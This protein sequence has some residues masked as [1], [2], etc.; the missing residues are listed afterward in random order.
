VSYTGPWE[1]AGFGKGFNP[2]AVSKETTHYDETENVTEIEKTVERQPGKTVWDLLAILLA[3]VIALA[4]ALLNRAQT[5]RAQA[6]Q[7]QSTQDDVLQDYFNQLGDLL[8]HKDTPLR[9]SNK[10]DE[11]RKLAR[12]RTLTTLGQLDGDRKRS[13]LQFLYESGLIDKTHPIID[14]SGADLK[15]ANLRDMELINADLSGAYLFGTDLRDTD[16]SS[17]DLRIAKLGGG[18]DLRGAR[19]LTQAQIEQARVDQTTKLPRDIKPPKSW[20]NSRVTQSN[21]E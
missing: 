11:V 7:H 20:D 14:L 1:R 15:D 18:A 17:A 19:N 8:L 16:L 21:G 3:P 2:N 5:E 10:D 9:G 12:A 6:A 13:L 4:V